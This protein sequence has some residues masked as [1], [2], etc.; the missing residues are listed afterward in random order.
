MPGDCGGHGAAQ[1]SDGCHGDLL[2][3]VLVRAGVSGGDHVGLEQGSLQVD[4]VVRQ[5]LVHSGK[6]LLSHVL[7]ALQVVVAVG[8]DLR[9]NN[10]DNAV[11]LADAG[12]AGQDVGVLKDGQFGG[13]GGDLQ[14]TA[15]LGE[16]GT[17][18]LVLGHTLIQAIKTLGGGLAV[19]SGKGDDTFVNLDSN[20]HASLLQELGE[21][22]A[23]VG[24]LVQGLV[25]EDDTTNCWLHALV[26]G[27]EQLTVQPP[28]LLSVLSIDALEALGNAAGR[29]VCGKD[30]LAGSDDLVSNVTE[31]LLLLR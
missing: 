8:E 31:L 21:E 17:V 13:G 22:H 14:H 3:G 20:N 18:L 27:E 23:I 12:I 15:P 2:V 9:L 11:H 10:G 16:I 24:L 4:V 25:E 29:L 26:S 30:S 19:G 7:A 6:D 5:G 1:G 28:V